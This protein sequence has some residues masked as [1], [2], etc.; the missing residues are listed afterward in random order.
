MQF[1]INGK[2]K[3]RFSIY[4]YHLRLPF[5]LIYVHLVLFPPYSSE[6]LLYP[7]ASYV[8]LGFILH[9]LYLLPSQLDPLKPSYSFSKLSFAE[10]SDAHPE[11]S[12]KNIGYLLSPPPPPSTLGLFCR[13]GQQKRAQNCLQPLLREKQKTFIPLNAE[14]SSKL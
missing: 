3:L 11:P 10:P 1:N 7:L 12:L 6:K 14:I 8:T 4:H 2:S 5:L 9:Y 13:E